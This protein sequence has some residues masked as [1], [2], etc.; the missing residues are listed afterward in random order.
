MIPD[1]E[2]PVG[3]APAPP[4]LVVVD[5]VVDVDPPVSFSSPAV[6]VTFTNGGGP[7]KLNPSSIKLLPAKSVPSL[8]SKVSVW[9]GSSCCQ[10]VLGPQKKPRELVQMAVFAS[11]PLKLHAS[12]QALVAQVSVIVIVYFLSQIVKGEIEREDG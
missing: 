8:P 9:Y 1:F 12:V 10:V 6:I 5:A 7:S 3:C 2:L 11:V 4:A